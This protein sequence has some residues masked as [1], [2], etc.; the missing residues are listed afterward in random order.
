DVPAFPQPSAVVGA[1][2]RAI[3]RYR[4]SLIARERAPTWLDARM[5][6]RLHRGL[7]RTGRADKSWCL[8]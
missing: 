7:R 3:G 8:V 1:R 5:N 2:L 6:P 4:E